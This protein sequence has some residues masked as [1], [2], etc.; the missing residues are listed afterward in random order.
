RARWE[1][2]RGSHGR[3]PRGR[4]PTSCRIA[5]DPDSPADTGDTASPTPWAKLSQRLFRTLVDP[6]PEL[7]QPSEGG[8]RPPF[9]R[10]VGEVKAGE[11]LEQGRDR[12]LRLEPRQ[13]RAETKMRA[14]SERLVAQLLA[15]GGEAAGLPIPAGIAIGSGERHHHGFAATNRTAA[16]LAIA[17]RDARGLDHRRLEAEHLLDGVRD[18]GGVFSELLELIRVTKQQPEAV[19]HQVGRP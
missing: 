6:Y 11:A 16:D 4:P 3:R 12:E 10:F 15:R 19:A 8:Q 17:H 9:E 5:P 2:G 14:A 18:Q 7:H 13:R 1:P